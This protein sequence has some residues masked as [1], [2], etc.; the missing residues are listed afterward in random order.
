M[1]DVMGLL[2]VRGKA[3]SGDMLGTLILMLLIV[4]ISVWVCVVPLSTSSPSDRGGVEH[5]AESHHYVRQYV[6]STFDLIIGCQLE[7]GCCPVFFLCP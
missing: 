1:P 3:L 4:A 2:V 6:E 7:H 5:S